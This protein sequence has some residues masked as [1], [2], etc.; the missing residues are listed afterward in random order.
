METKYW[1]QINF[2]G[3]IESA[4]T[5]ARY[6]LERL[7]AYQEF[8]TNFTFTEAIFVA[9]S[10]N[11]ATY[12]SDHMRRYYTPGLE[13]LVENFYSEDYSHPILNLTMSKIFFDGTTNVSTDGAAVRT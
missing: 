12:S 4:A 2:V 1:S 6:L 10:A 13:R 3:R 5:H 8:G 9:N 11:H 7:N